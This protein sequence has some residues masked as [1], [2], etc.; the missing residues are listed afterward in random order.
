MKDN[1]NHPQL[2]IPSKGG[3][4]SMNIGEND[5]EGSRVVKL[6]GVKI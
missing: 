4:I 6:L 5:I 2:L 1:D 3:D